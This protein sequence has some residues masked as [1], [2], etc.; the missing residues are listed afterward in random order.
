MSLFEKMCARKITEERA[1]KKRPQPVLYRHASGEISDTKLGLVR[2]FEHQGKITWS[3][4]YE[5]RELTQE[6][7]KALEGFKDEYRRLHKRMKRFMEKAYE[8]ARVIT[9]EEG[10]AIT[11]EREAR[12]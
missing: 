10:K 1:C 12:P 9:P 4:M 6:D 8:R 7:A 2:A 3:M 5:P 11:D